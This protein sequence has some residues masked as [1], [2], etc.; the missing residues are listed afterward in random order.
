ME[1]ERIIAEIKI[2]LAAMGFGNEVQDIS[3]HQGVTTR[4]S[5]RVRESGMAGS[6]LLE[7]EMLLRDVGAGENTPSATSVLIGERGSNLGAIEH[8][9]KKIIRKKYGEEQKFTLDINDYRMRRLDDLKQDVKTAAK[10]VRLYGKQV[11]LRPMS[12]FE[13]RIVHLLLAE[14]PDIATESIGREPGR[15]VVIKPYP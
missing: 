1:T 9:V 8:I 11:P 4:I 5:V 3:V 12:S 13:R 7:P 15:M 14:Y 6:D 2:L 10:E